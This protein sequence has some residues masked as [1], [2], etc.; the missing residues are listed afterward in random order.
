MRRVKLLSYQGGARVERKE[1]LTLQTR[2]QATKVG[3]AE[4]SSR[5]GCP[6]RNS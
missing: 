6:A 3:C 4:S 2:I 1:E 5:S